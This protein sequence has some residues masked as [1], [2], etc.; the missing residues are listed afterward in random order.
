M[1]LGSHKALLIKFGPTPASLRPCKPN[2]E[3]GMPQPRSTDAVFVGGWPRSWCGVRVRPSG[4]R[5]SVRLP[6]GFSGC[7]C[8][9]LS[10]WPRWRRHRGGCPA[11]VAT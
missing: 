10:A 4:S 3:T 9:G 6:L 7:A 5:R 11:H 2:P 1:F 8:W